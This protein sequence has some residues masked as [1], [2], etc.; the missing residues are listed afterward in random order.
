[1]TGRPQDRSYFR[2]PLAAPVELLWDGPDEPCHLAGV[3]V[4]ISEG[5][6]LAAVRGEPPEAGTAV[7]VRLVLDGRELS[8]AAV[9]VRR[10]TLASGRPAV[11]V[12]FDDPDEH[13]DRIRRV[14]F[15]LERRRA[16]AR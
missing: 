13:G 9:V 1:M 5:G 15:E 7:E 2:A 4:D 16:W 12:A 6:L 10:A 3:L 8:A 11:A 14:V